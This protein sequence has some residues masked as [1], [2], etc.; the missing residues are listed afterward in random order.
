MALKS[1]RV[2]KK[3][4][5]YYYTPKVSAYEMM[6]NSVNSPMGFGQIIQSYVGTEVVNTYYHIYSYTLRSPVIYDVTSNLENLPGNAGP[7]FWGVSSSDGEAFINGQISL[8]GLRKLKYCDGCSE[9]NGL[10]LPIIDNFSKRFK[11]VEELVSVNGLFE[12][13]LFY[14]LSLPR[15]SNVFP[16]IKKDDGVNIIYQFKNV[17]TGADLTAEDVASITQKPVLEIEDSVD[18]APVIKPQEGSNTV[19]TSCCDEDVSYVIPGRYTIGTI[20]NIDGLSESSCWYVESLTNELP[21]T[22]GMVAINGQ[23]RSCVGCISKFPCPTTGSNTILVGCCDGLEYIVEGTLPYPE[24]SIV[25]TKDLDP[26]TCFTVYGT[27]KAKS[28]YTFQV[29]SWKTGCKECTSIYPGGCK[30]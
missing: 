15:Y 16:A 27:T 21:N 8:P 2:T 12:G 10:Q 11:Q 25:Y 24:K 1:L 26:A 5:Q 19:I 30:G 23:Q 20:Y 4:L 22:P 13:F 7:A 18:T 28:E 9:S 14:D 17:N 29:T 3:E 6:V